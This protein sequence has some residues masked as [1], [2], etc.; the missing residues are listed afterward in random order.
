MKSSRSIISLAALA[1]LSEFSPA[2][3]DL[4]FETE[5][6]R[7]PEVGRTEISVAGEYQHSREGGEF[8]L[9]FAYEIGLHPRF[10]LLLEPT[11]YVAIYH[12]GER[13][14]QGVGDTEITGTFLALPEAGAWPAFAVAGEVKLPTARNLK[15]GT[16]KTDYAL[17]LIASKRL[18]EV[19]LHANVAYT[20]FGKPTGISVSDTMTFSLAADLKQNAKFAT[21]AEVMFTTSALGGSGEGKGAAAEIGVDEFI[22]T[23][24]VRHHPKAGVS[25]FA[26]VSYDNGHAVLFRLG[27]THL[28]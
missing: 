7:M 17:Y 3:A 22:G 14:V 15:I 9:P 25:A 6:A 12:R 19:D 18:A 2:R 26:S 4:S 8:A 24:G 21:F 13:R 23:V 5:T 11:P 10:A 16:R 1:L 20:F 27:V 28:F